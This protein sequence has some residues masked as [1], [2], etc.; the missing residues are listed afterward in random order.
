MG[1]SDV[2]AK[3]SAHDVDGPLCPIGR[4]SITTCTS[5]FEV[6]PEFDTQWLG[7]D[8]IALFALIASP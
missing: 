1:E 7:L 8:L 2:E 5:T 6:H 4:F 3:P